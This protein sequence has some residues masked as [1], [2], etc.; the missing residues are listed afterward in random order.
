[1]KNTKN[2]ILTTIVTILVIAVIAFVIIGIGFVMIKSIVAFL[3][4]FVLIF[5]ILCY[6]EYRKNHKK[7]F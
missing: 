2:A 3:I 1:M 6:K 7:N 5:A 4:R